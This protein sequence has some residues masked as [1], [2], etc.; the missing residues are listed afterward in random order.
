MHAEVAAL[1]DRA[2]RLG[3]DPRNTNY[4]G[5]NTSAK[6]EEVDPGERIGLPRQQQDRASDG[7]PMGDPRVRAVRRAGRMERVA[8]QHQGGIGRVRLGCGEARDPATE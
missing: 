8:E 1:L 6:D 2:H 4:A 3:R 5:G 7:R